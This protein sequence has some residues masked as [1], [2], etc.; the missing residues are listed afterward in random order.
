MRIVGMVAVE[1]LSLSVYTGLLSAIVCEFENHYTVELVR[2]IE[3][4]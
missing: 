3:N 1:I 4:W 2:R